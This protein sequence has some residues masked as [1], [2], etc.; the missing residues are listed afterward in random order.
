MGKGAQSK[1]TW[2]KW[3]TTT[4]KPAISAKEK[5]QVEKLLR[6]KPA[7][8]ELDYPQEP[9]CEPALPDETTAKKRQ[10]EQRNIKGKLDW[11]NQ[12]QAI[13]D[14]GPMIENVKGDEVDN[15]VKSLIHLSLGTEGT[16]IFHQHNPDT[17]LSK[18][19]TNALVIQLQDTFEEIRNKTFDSFQFFRCTQNPRESLEQFHSRLKQKAALCNWEDLEDSLVKSI[20]IQGMSNPQ[21]QMDLLSESPSGSGINLIQRPRQQTPRRSILPP[22]PI[23][24]KIPDCWKC[25]YKFIKGHLDN[26][27]T[28]NSICNICKKVGHYAKVCRSDIAPRRSEIKNTPRNNQ[29]YNNRSQ[30]PNNTKQQTNARRVRN[31]QSI[32]ENESIQQ[33]EEAETETI[34]PENTCYI[35]ETMENWSSLNFIQSL[36]FTTV[37][38]NDLNKNQQGEFWIQSRSKDEDINWLVEK[39]SPRSFISRRTAQNLTKKLGNKIVKQDKN[40]GEFRCFNN[41]KIKVDYSIQLDLVTGNTKHTTAKSLLSRKTQ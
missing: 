33:E 26:C 5:I 19:T 11:K 20:F 12:C 39:G 28:K 24:N 1:T 15:K 9:I 38:K 3:I 31:I 21:I 17:E 36:N 4:T 18:C 35:R 32:P 14:Q 41:N 8:E 34:D 6:P 13:E 2:E 29:N 23:N 10:R 16:N 7:A 25:G 30:Q 27:P 37:T 22:P 40:I